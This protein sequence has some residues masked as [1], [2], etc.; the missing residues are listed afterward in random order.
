MLRWKTGRSYLYLSKKLE[1]KDVTRHGFC[2]DSER[3]LLESCIAIKSVFI[4]RDFNFSYRHFRLRINTLEA[5]RKELIEN[6]S[7]MKEL[8]NDGESFDDFVSNLNL[9]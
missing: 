4:D 3:V 7:R 9:H 6:V 1:A 5:D 8:V 2:K